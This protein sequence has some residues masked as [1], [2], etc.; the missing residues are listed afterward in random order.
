MLVSRPV[1]Q[2]GASLIEVLVAVLI[3][4]VGLLGYA[5]VQT[6]AL[7]LNSDALQQAH[8][9]LLADDWFDR[10][11]ANRNQ[12]LNSGDYLFDAPPDTSTTENCDTQDCTALQIARRDLSQWQ[13]QLSA[14]IPGATATSERDGQQFRLTIRLSESIAGSRP[15]LRFMTR[16]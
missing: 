10:L 8:A 9:S 3:L 16:L 6:R 5:S 2:G 11:R 4:A 13:Q 15:E 14:T 7:R 1:K 12:A